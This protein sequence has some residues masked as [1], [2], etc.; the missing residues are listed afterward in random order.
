MIYIFL[1]S[2]FVFVI[3]KQWLKL[4][5]LEGNGQNLLEITSFKIFM[6]LYNK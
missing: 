6:T 2:V 1:K 4:E 3:L 5:I